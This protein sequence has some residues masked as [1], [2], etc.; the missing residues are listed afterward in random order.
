M[1]GGDALNIE[2][3]M[4]RGMFRLLILS[5]LKKS[6][7]RGYQILKVIRH[8]TGRKPSM[9][10]IHDILTEL[11]RRNLIRSIITQTSEK[12]YQITDFGE[13][14]LNEIRI[15]CKSRIMKVLHLIFEN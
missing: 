10:T 7:M 15:R 3:A 9:S 13:R 6:R 1:S 5:L 14:T 4:F 8:L 11:E 2:W 12:Y